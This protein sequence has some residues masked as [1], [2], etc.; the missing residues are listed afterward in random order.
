MLIEAG[1]AIKLFWIKNTIACTTSSGCPTR[2]RSLV[3][4][5]D[6]SY[7]RLVPI[8]R[9]GVGLSGTTERKTTRRCKSKNSGSGSIL[10]KDEFI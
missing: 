9:V 3:G 5:S 1:S 2:P 10:L 7:H 8:D 6:A 4:A